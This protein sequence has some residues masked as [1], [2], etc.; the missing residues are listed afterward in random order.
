MNYKDDIKAIAFDFD[1]TLIDFNYNTTDYTRKA[2]DLLKNSKYKVCLSSGR[3][4]FL[5]KKAFEDKFGKYPLDYIF[6]CNGSEM[7][8]CKNDKTEI[9]FPLKAQDVRQLG[10]VLDVDFLM[11]GI[12]DGDKFL[13][14]HYRNTKGTND[15]LNARWL[16]PIEYDFSQNEIDRSKVIIINDVEDR[17][18]ENDFLKNIDLTKYSSA[19]S[20]PNCFEIAPK[21]VSKAKAIER[22]ASILNCDNSQILSFGDMPNDLPMLLNSTGVVMENASDEM[23]KQVPLKT[24]R[25]DEMGVYEFLHNNQLI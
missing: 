1:G 6:G 25:V 8:D 4:C 20:S 24:S 15:W 5:A 11:L 13:V 22:L 10:K 9:L 23:K 12:Y 16:K 18:K 2:L 19:Y 21:G 7:M 14:N 17:E 3:P